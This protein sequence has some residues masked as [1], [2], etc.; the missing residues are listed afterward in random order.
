MASI[1]KEIALD[2]A[3]ETVWDV[4]RDVGAVHTRFAPGFVI[5]VTME[6]GARLVTFGNGLVAREVIVDVDER[7]RRL[8]YSVRSERLSHHNA[9][10]QVVA[11]ERGSRLVWIADVLPHEAAVQVGAMMEAGLVAAKTKLDCA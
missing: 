7:L 11:A 4:V 3:P 5:D 9:S 2:A 1:H 6:D 8:A 10:F